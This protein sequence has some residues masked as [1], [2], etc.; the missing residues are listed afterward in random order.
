MN[1][2]ELTDDELEGVAGGARPR[3]ADWD[4]QTGLA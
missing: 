2:S 1:Q 3:P 4:F